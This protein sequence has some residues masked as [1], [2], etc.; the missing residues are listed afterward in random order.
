VRP[1]REIGEKELAEIE[2]LLKT[3]RSA[4]ELKAIQCV[5]MRACEG[6][7]AKEIAILIGWSE[8]NVKRVQSDYFKRGLDA[9]KR[10]QSAHRRRGNMTFEGEEHFIAPFLDEAKTGGIINV[11]RIKH[12]Y[13][14]VLGRP[15]HKSVIYRL[16]GRHGWRKIAPRPRHPKSDKEAQELFKKTA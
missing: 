3:A 16:L 10:E 7:T 5:W 14:E 11:S 4:T 12:A 1:R 8:S 15:V 2:Q 13:E 9:F 6:K